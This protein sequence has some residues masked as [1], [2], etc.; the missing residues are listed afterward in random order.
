MRRAEAR[1]GQ[2]A[3]GLKP[4]PGRLRGLLVRR[5]RLGVR[6]DGL[7]VRPGRLGRG[8][9]VL[10]GRLRN[11]R[12][13]AHGLETRRGGL[14]RGPGGGCVRR[15][16]LLCLGPHGL[17]ARR[18]G[19]RRGLLVRRHG[20]RG[21][22]DGLKTGRGRLRHARGRGVRS[23]GLLVLRYALRGGRRLAVRRYGL[24]RGGSHGLR[25]GT[26]GCAPEPRA[27][28]RAPPRS[29]RH[30]EPPE[31]PLGARHV[32]TA[33]YLTRRHWR[34]RSRRGHLGG[35]LLPGN[36]PRD[37][38]L[39]GLAR[40]LAL[41]LV[42]PG[43]RRE[44][45]ARRGL[46]RRRPLVRGGQRAPAPSRRLRLLVRARAL[47][48]HVHGD[49]AGRAVGLSA[50]GQRG[51]ERL[52]LTGRAPG[53]ASGR[54]GHTLRRY[55]PAQPG[56]GGRGARRVL[57]RGD[58]GALGHPRPRRRTGEFDLRTRRTC[59]GRR[60][61]GGTATPPPG[62]AGR[63]RALTGRL[64]RKLGLLGLGL[65]RLRGPG[66]S[67]PPPAPPG[68]LR[69]LRGRDGR[70]LAVTTRRI[71]LEERVD[72]RPPRPAPSPPCVGSA[73]AAASSACGAASCGTDPAPPPIGTSRTNALPL[74]PGTSCVWSTPPCARTM[75]RTTG[76][77]TGSP[78]PYGPRTSMRTTSP[79]WA[80]ATTTVLSR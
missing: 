9:L 47:G 58:D 18:G 75:P 57:G 15:Y 43:R 49:R 17:E 14:G 11:L 65:L 48:G 72:G 53:P 69:R 12:V 8:L 31:R 25:P 6:T 45:R 73:G 16:G 7:E 67:R 5:N 78:P 46:L 35:G 70:S 13:R 30:P 32:L 41:I 3:D 63:G 61:L 55:G 42:R 20:L 40:L 4:G 37:L 64:G 44:H 33:R 74:I 22:P 71:T 54:C 24:T 59:R 27:A 10:R 34:L 66:R 26:T 52:L 39:R 79:R 2:G 77:C 62:P 50:R 36:L 68:G 1:A 56:V 60:V 29:A 38:V 76:S 51:R 21:G 23:G 80:A 19:L 28:A